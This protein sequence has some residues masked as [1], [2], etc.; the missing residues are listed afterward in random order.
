[1]N[2]KCFRHSRFAFQQYW[3]NRIYLTRITSL[4]QWFHV[5]RGVILLY[6]YSQEEQQ[7]ELGY[8]PAEWAKFKIMQ[9]RKQLNLT[10]EGTHDL[11]TSRFQP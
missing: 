8:F 3:V 7:K 2:K 1:Q 10:E 6:Y 11:H 5:T 9:R 4:Y